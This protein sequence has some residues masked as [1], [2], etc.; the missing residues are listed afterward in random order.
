MNDKQRTYHT[1]IANG[2]TLTK[3]E[4]D[5]YKNFEI[6]DQINVYTVNDFNLIADFT[7]IG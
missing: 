2:I 3:V 5:F 7:Y 1:E 4:T 6:L